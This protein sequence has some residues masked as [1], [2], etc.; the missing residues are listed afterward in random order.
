MAAQLA[1]SQEGFSSMSDDRRL[2]EL[3][4]G[5]MPITV[6]YLIPPSSELGLLIGELSWWM[7]RGSEKRQWQGAVASNFTSSGPLIRSVNF[8]PNNLTVINLAERFRHRPKVPKALLIN[9]TR[10]QKMVKKI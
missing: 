2:L 1:A 8:H 6:P 3:Q 5:S 7:S 4:K 9:G 10:W